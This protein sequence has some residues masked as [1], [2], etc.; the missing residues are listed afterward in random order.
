MTH[1]RYCNFCHKQK[2]YDD[3]PEGSVAWSGIFAC[4]DCL[5]TDKTGLFRELVEVEDVDLNNG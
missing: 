3:W 2:D 1:L 4:A 5:Q